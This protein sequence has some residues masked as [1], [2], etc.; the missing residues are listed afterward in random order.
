MSMVEERMAAIGR[1]RE[2]LEELSRDHPCLNRYA[3]GLN[4]F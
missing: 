2:F 3:S 4:A 1:I